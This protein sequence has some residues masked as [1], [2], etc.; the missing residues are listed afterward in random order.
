MLIRGFLVLTK[1]ETLEF[2]IGYQFRAL[3]PLL[4]WMSQTAKDMGMFQ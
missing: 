2:W 3:V 1:F 4:I